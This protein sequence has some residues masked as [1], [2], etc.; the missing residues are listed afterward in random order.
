MAKARTA[1]I[2]RQTNETSIQVRIKLDGSGK[3][4]ISTGVGFLDHMLD[5]WSHHSRIDLEI[6]AEGDLQVDEHHVVEDVGIALGQAFLQASGERKG[7][8]RY[9]FFILPM[10]EVLALAAVDLSGRFAFATNYSPERETVGELS[11]EMVAH[12]FRSFACE[13]RISLHLR[14]LEPGSNEHHRIEALFKA[15]AR[16]IR[17]ALSR[18]AGFESEIPSTKGVL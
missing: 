12:F 5:L 1:E 15:S 9:G 2:R 3:S 4:K 16:A 11:T 17:S 10:D 8:R 13:A 14:I 6:R 18:E 7:V